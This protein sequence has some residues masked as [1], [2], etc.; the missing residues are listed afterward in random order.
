[1]NRRP[2]LLSSFLL[3]SQFNRAALRM[4]L[5]LAYP[6][7]LKVMIAETRTKPATNGHQ[8]GKEEHFGSR[9]EHRTKHRPSFSCRQRQQYKHTINLGVDDLAAVY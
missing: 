1:M 3:H 9:S 7:S 2:L 6:N 5:P 8:G 4:G